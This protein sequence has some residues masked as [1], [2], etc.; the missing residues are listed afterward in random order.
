MIFVLEVLFPETVAG[1]TERWCHQTEA[2]H[3]MKTSYLPGNRLP[4]SLRSLSL[5]AF[6]A[7]VSCTKSHHRFGMTLLEII[8]SLGVLAGVLAVI[9]NLSRLSNQS[10]ASARDTTEAQFLCESIMARLTSGII[11]F[12]SVFDVP[13]YDPVYDFDN[14]GT[15]YSNYSYNDTDPKWFY[16]IEINTLDDYGLLEVIVLVEQNLPYASREPVTCRLVRWMLDKAMAQETLESE[17]ASSA[18]SDS[19]SASENSPT[20]STGSPGGGNNTG[21]GTIDNGD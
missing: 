1:K 19:G 8:L 11:E 14:A 4:R 13:V 10:A 6:P 5:T 9:A 15:A 16:S 12:E 2:M 7:A 17:A 20:D 18:S 3:Q 21:T